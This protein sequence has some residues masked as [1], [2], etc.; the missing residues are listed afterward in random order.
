[1]TQLLSLPPFPPYHV[2]ETFALEALLLALLRGGGGGGVALSLP[3]RDKQ[4]SRHYAA[5][6]SLSHREAGVLALHTVSPSSDG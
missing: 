5:S 2:R 4:L 3:G 6:F 1:M